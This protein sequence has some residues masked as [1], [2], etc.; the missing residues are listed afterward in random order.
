MLAE[1]REDFGEFRKTFQLVNAILEDPN[2]QKNLR[3]TIE[4]LPLLVQDGRLAFQRIAQ[5]SEEAEGM[6]RD[7]RKDVERLSQRIEK[8]ISTRTPWYR[9]IESP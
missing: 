4:G 3:D 9:K 7:A 6:I 8:L 5:V 1:V 2:R